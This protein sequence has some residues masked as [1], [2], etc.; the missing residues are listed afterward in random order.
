MKNYNDLHL[1]TLMVKLKKK[2][3]RKKICKIMQI[4]KY[5]LTL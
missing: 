3:K 1:D 5:R 4:R 2:L